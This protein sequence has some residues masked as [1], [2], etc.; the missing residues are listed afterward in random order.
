MQTL[1]QYLYQKCEW[2]VKAR[3]FQ[4]LM[5]F[6]ILLNPIAIF[7]Q[8]VVVFTAPSVAGVSV[9]A[10]GIFA[11]IQLAFLFEGIRTKNAGVFLA[12][13]VSLMESITI[14]TVVLMRS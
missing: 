3:W 11:A 14:I 9:Q 10:F 6:I 7:P 1:M 12:M 5:T 2:L 13:V 4:F 8:V